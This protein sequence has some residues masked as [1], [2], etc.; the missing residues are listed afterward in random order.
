MKGRLN[1][2]TVQNALTHKN[3]K[4]YFI[5]FGLACC[6][7]AG[8]LDWLV[9]VCVVRVVFMWAWQLRYALVAGWSQHGEI[10]KL[11]MPYEMVAANGVRH[12]WSTYYKTLR[13]VIWSQFS[14]SH[15]PWG[16]Q[17]PPM[18]RLKTTPS[19]D[20]SATW[21]PYTPNKFLSTLV[22]FDTWQAQGPERISAGD[23]EVD[24]WTAK[25]R[26]WVINHDVSHSTIIQT[27]V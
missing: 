24:M 19:E 21:Y 9:V 7:W 17:H 12:C 4:T 13:H 6:H 10:T 14:A 2:P 16:W 3:K 15:Q 25:E 5:P 20:N 8:I 11:N 23:A 27:K 1:C 22:V 18:M 26:R